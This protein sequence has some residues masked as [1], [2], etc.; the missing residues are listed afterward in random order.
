MNASQL[1]LIQRR[2]IVFQEFEQLGFGGI[3]AF[4][5]VCLS[6]DGTL[7]FWELT[8]FFYWLKCEES[9]VSKIENVLEILKHE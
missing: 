9:T 8:W 5:N 3:Q 6:V 2:A 7:S 4:R 1:S